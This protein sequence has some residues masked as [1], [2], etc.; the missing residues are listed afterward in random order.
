MIRWTRNVFT[1]P[2]DVLVLLC[3]LE[4]RRSLLQW[5][6]SKDLHNSAGRFR[7]QVPN[8]KLSPTSQPLAILGSCCV[9]LTLAHALPVERPGIG[10][11]AAPRFR[12]FIF[13]Q[14]SPKLTMP[15]HVTTVLLCLKL[16]MTY[17]SLTLLKKFFAHQT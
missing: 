7:L 12:S 2:R 11:L 15:L 6:R 10:V 4:R 8:P 17:S 13:Q 16:L 14:L 1:V 9:I 3:H 5:L